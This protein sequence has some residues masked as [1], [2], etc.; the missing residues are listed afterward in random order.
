M[1]KKILPFLLPLLIAAP[2]AQADVNLIAIGQ[3]N[4]AYQDLSPRTSDVLENGTPG[5]MLGGIASGLAYAGGNTFITI[6]DRGPNAVAYNPNVDDTVSYINRFQTFNLALAANPDYDALTVGSLPYILSPQLTATTLLSSKQALIYGTNG[7]PALNN[8]KKYYFSGR[9]D[10]FKASGKSTNPLNGRLDP[11][12]IRVAK[13]GKSVFITDEYGPYVYQF[14]RTGG[15]RIKTFKL[16]SYYTITNLNAMGD[17]EISGNTSG[18]IANKG[19]EALAITPDGTTLVGMMQQNLIQDT[20]KYVRI[21]TIDIASGAT[22]EYAYKLTDG[23]SIS[24]ILAIN[25]HEFLVDERDGAGLGDGTPAVVKKLFKIDLSGATEISTPTI[26]STTPLVS[27]TEFLDV[28]A[29]LNANGITSDNIPAK[30]EGVAFGPDLVVGGVTK[31]T[32]FIANDNDFLPSVNGVANP[33]QF[34]VFTIDEADLPNFVPQTIAPFKL[35][36]NDRG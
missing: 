30:L 22:H 2:V 24:D 23:S 3:V 11:E 25:D 26:G 15:N 5:N 34:F 18:R 27:K 33:N 19:M 32:L 21:I 31:H 6:P 20:K 17:T 8:S 4:G 28:V 1:T 7:A 12:G 13:D 9:S 16:P 29:K 10:N 36:S 35:D 14:D